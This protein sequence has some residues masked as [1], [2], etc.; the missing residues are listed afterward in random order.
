MLRM[1]VQ[2]LQQRQDGRAKQTIQKC[3]K[4]QLFHFQTL[5]FSGFDTCLGSVITYI[6]D[7]NKPYDPRRKAVYP[8]HA[9]SAIKAAT[10]THKPHRKPRKA[11]EKF[12]NIA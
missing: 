8:C 7:F 10:G 11:K 3:G 6:W 12:L 5:R 2:R 1:N 4:S 9:A